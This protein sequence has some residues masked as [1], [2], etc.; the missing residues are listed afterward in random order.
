MCAN[1]HAN[2]FYRRRCLGYGGSHITSTHVSSSYIQ[3]ASSSTEWISF[4]AY[5]HNRLVAVFRGN[6]RLIRIQ[7]AQ[8][9]RRNTCAKNK[10]FLIS[11]VLV[12][13]APLC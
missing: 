7:A 2:P 9:V 4:V 10:P 5:M 13:V 12:R 3:H 8:M 1:M 6:T 11:T